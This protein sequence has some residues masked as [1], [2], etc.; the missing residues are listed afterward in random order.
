MRHALVVGLLLALPARAE[1][2]HALALWG[3]AE[4]TLHPVVDWHGIARIR[5]QLS[6]LPRQSRLVVDFNTDTLRLGLDGVRLGRFELGVG[7][8]GEL[9]IAGLLGDYWRDGHR[10]AARGFRA[11]WASAGS[12]LKLDLAPSYL[13]LAVAA[14]RW[15]FA[16]TDATAADFELPP[17]AWVGE[18]R[19][20][21]TL[22]SLRPDPSLWEAQRPFARLDGVAFGVELGLDARSEARPWGARG[23]SF[24]PPDL[25]ND[26]SRVGLSARQWLLLGIRL[27]PRVRLQIEEQALWMSGADDLGRARIGGLNPYSVP[28]AG[29][30]WPAY[31][32][33]RLAAMQ[34]TLPVRVW[35]EL[36]LGPLAGA[37]VLDDVDRTGAPLRPGARVGVGAFVDFRLRGWQVDVRGGF[38][39]RDG[40]SLFAALGWGWSR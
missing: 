30:P 37:V 10:D 8:G 21:Y 19:L 6:G 11:S 15:F 40:V 38:S 7:A 34:L 3:G 33:G 16:R 25:R 22:W 2:H 27:A 39:P 23:S 18:W 17:E 4:L 13:E 24:T 12:Y 9:F 26:P 32:A 28:V 1:R 31:L 5:Y 35:R 20:R 29:L 14:R 36:E